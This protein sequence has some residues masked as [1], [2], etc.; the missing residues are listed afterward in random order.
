MKPDMLIFAAFQFDPEASQHIRDLAGIH[1]MNILQA[2]MNTDL[3]T[4][5]L[6]K[7]LKTD[8]SFWLVGQPD[9]E[10]IRDTGDRGKG[11]GKELY[12]VR[13][14]GFDYYNVKA[15]KVDSGNADK[16]AMW[17]LDP[18]Y[19]GA[20]LNPSQVFFPMGKGW[21]KLPNTLK[22]E[23]DADLLEA[24]SGT[25]SLPFKA[26]EKVAV[27]VIDDRGI[28]SMRVLYREEAE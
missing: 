20:T 6:R 5:D 27:K 17:M 9:V 28:E 11:L 14:L 25:E 8:Q 23:L 4:E 12:R 18:D 2:Q 19:D 10:L 24:Y 15:G 22:A 21:D 7:K 16:I 13:V 1:S 3:M 26:G